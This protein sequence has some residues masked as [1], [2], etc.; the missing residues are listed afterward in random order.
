M[1]PSRFVP[2]TLVDF[3]GERLGRV[4]V[5]G[6]KRKL[7]AKDRQ[8]RRKLRRARALKSTISGTRKSMPL[9]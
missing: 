5:A 3:S 1:N 7:T 2:A 6:P 4:D 9:V 8:I